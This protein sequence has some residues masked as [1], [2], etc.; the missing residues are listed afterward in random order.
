[1][2]LFLD[3]VIYYSGLQMRVPLKHLICN[4]QYYILHI[5]YTGIE[6]APHGSY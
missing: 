2:K 6:P 1:M 4:M 3:F 5:T